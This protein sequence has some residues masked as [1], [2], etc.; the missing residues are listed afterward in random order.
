MTV[1]V[2]NLAAT[3]SEVIEELALM[4]V[5]VAEELEEFVPDTAGSIDFSGPVNGRLSA[6]CHRTLGTK[7]ASNLLGLEPDDDDAHEKACDAF[8]E[9]LNVICGNLVTKVFDP[10]RTFTISMPQVENP[11]ESESDEPKSEDADVQ[12]AQNE[13]KWSF[14]ETCTLLLDE[15]PVEFTLSFFVGPSSEH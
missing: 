4:T 9:M 7:L 11:I 5:E 12:E 14:Q 13:G 10:E 6:R 8:G 2:K 3:I 15:S 1:V